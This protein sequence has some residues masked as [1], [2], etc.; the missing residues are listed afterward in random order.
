M[1]ENEWLKF[2]ND[3]LLKTNNFNKQ[4]ASEN[5]RATNLLNEIALNVSNQWINTHKKGIEQIE[6]GYEIQGK[7]SAKKYDV[8]NR[9]FLIYFHNI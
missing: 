6:K 8:N 1:T 9:K 3:I 5:A 4:A 2:T 7:M